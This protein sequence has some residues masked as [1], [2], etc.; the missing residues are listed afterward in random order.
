MVHQKNADVEF[1]FA[2]QGI[3]M[4]VEGDWVRANGT[5][6]GSDNGIGVAMIMGPSFF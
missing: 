3:D 5:T 6:L 1:D 4:I 2:T